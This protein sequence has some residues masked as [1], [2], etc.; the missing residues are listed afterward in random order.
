LSTYYQE[1][2]TGKMEKDCVVFR[3]KLAERRKEGRGR[4]PG[5]VY[6][7]IWVA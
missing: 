4:L 3:A 1:G 5:A 7:C 6:V 2:Y